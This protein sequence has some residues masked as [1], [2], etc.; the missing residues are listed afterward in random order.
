MN[1]CKILGILTCTALALIA[2]P[3]AAAMR[4]CT[5]T[6]LQ[7]V[8]ATDAPG[9]ASSVAIKAAR[10]EYESFQVVVT[11]DARS[12]RDAD[13]AI[14]DFVDG[15]GHV[16]TAD[17]V[18]IYR[19][20]FLKIRRLSDAR[21]SKGMWPDALYPKV[22]PFF[23]ETRN[24]FPFRVRRGRN[25]PLWFDVYVPRTTPAGTYAATVTVTSDAGTTTVPVTL[26]VW[27]FTLPS[28]QTLESVVGFDEFEA[29]REHDPGSRFDYDYA[30]ILPELTGPYMAAFARNR[31][32]MTYASQDATDSA[33]I[34][35]A[36]PPVFDW[37]RFDATVGAALDG[38]LPGSN[39]NQLRNLT[40]PDIDRPNAEYSDAEKQQIWSAFADHFSARG[41]SDRLL[42][43]S[44]YIVD[45][46]RPNE[47]PAIQTHAALV[48]G[49]NP[50]LRVLAT[51]PIRLPNDA[52]PADH[53][54]QIESPL[55]GSLDVWVPI[56]AS[57]ATKD[58][59]TCSSPDLEVPRAAYD[60]R[61]AAGDQVWLYQSCE[62]HDCGAIGN[63]CVRNYPTYMVDAPATHNRIS[64]WMSWQQRV[65]GEL[66]YESV[67]AYHA[68]RS[69]LRS[70]YYF[71]GNGD[72]TLFYPGIPRRI[73]G[74]HHI[75]IE[76]LRLKQI[77]DGME[78]FELMAL[79]RSVGQQAF[80][81]AQVNGIV[82]NTYTFNDDPAA[83]LAAREA[84][85][86]QLHSLA[87]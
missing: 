63:D 12:L 48:H 15:L 21:G 28:K 54:D 24:S 77:R 31:I 22:D 33:F 26:T 72:G 76:S 11:A 25:Q 8:K 47:L 35:R 29:M 3:S 70:I 30:R 62:S 61:V 42:D 45:E 32:G 43:Y 38:T 18:T 74:T 86:E 49:A 7:K 5:A 2:R 80:A 59:L 69:P 6:S 65:S 16:I 10:N 9:S 57:L 34:Y 20:E 27:N 83:L 75:P 36:H 79:L 13:A 56:V 23:G 4:V 41:W 60:A 44:V 53:T 73:G 84:M 40:L 82:T 68:S 17:Q 46:P 39:G 81:D 52:T 1:R 19:Q 51:T 85:G 66:Y 14:S 37:T 78:D 58:P 64:E 71:T 50:A 67:F 55:I 87:P